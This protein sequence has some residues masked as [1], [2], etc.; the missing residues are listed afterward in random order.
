MS[1]D[2]SKDLA[3]A[4]DELAVRVPSSLA[5]LARLAFNYW[6]SWTPGAPELF[7]EIDA[8]RFD[9]CRENPVRLL[10]EAPAPSLARA[11]RD[12]AFLHR[13]ETVYERFERVMASGSGRSD[14]A[15]DRP[16]AFF[17]LEYGIHPSLPNYSGGLG[18][19]AG[20]ILKEASD[21]GLPMVGLGL[22]Y[23]QGSY[24][25][26]LDPDGW[27]HDYW[28]E[29][30]PEFLP[31]ALVTG[32]D[33]EALTV[34]VP[35]RGRDVVAQIWRV[36][37]GRVPLYLLD[38]RRPEND[39]IDRWITSRL[40]V[41]DPKIRLAQYALVGLGGV[42]T[43]RAL[44]ISPG[45]LHLNEGHPALAPLELT[46]DAV[47]SGRPFDDALQEVRERTVFTT[48]TPVPAGNET[49]GPKVILEV[50]GD[51][52]AALGIDHQRF[53]RMGSLG[54][55]PS[56]GFGMTTLALRLARFS[57]GV[58]RRHGEVARQMW[59]DLFPGMRTDQVPIGHVTN[60]VHLPSWMATEMRELL[61]LYLPDG[62]VERASDPSV[63][64]GVDNIP[65]E[66]LWAVRNLL[67]R[68]LVSFARTRSALDRLARGESSDSVE[69]AREVFDP[70][71]LTIGFARRVA[72]Y[73]RLYLLT[74]D[75]ARADGLLEGP[76]VQV[77]IA[78]KAHP[79]DQEAKRSLQALFAHRWGRGAGLRVT[80]L[81][82]YDIGLA[83]RLVS[84]CDLWLNL[85]RPPLEASG[86]SGMKSALNGGLNLSV[87]DGW[88]A[89]AYD[90]SNGWI[91]GGEVSADPERQDAEDAQAL[92]DLVEGQ[93]V[94]LFY[95]RDENGLPH[96]W[97]AKIKASLRSVGPG[98]SASRMMDD[99]ARLA[100]RDRELEQAG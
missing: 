41:S 68:H 79:D 59:A 10:R 75:P 6:W 53:L 88:W 67:R 64:D 83:R 39:V 99:Y 32:D 27:Q 49:Y 87:P 58:S 46:T 8:Q 54:D 47:A 36:D 20:D 52:P 94:P 100:Y 81:E 89:E 95:D 90:G 7:R 43:L 25:Q 1:L 15:P 98:F 31:L 63:W 17:C 38:T 70:D 24:H 23:S 61:D 2:G 29:T 91:I 56:G 72:L 60:G 57:G 78:G 55:D 12:A 9:L 85:P 73:K 18:V 14:V 34:V 82:D 35:V 11:A 50:L 80:Y 5:P 77:L 26:R 44:G 96:G 3:R 84:G 13:M 16:V 62:W 74:Q 37:V 30:D 76:P 21:R 66:E 97:L 45:T 86:T 65:D 33:G 93:V 4:A 28:V 92:F 71:A 51:L 42:R 40:Y 69:M 48:H 22:L 19:L